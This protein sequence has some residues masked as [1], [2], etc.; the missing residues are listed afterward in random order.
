MLQCRLV[1]LAIAGLMLQVLVPDPSPLLRGGVDGSAAAPSSMLDWLPAAW[2]ATPAYAGPRPTPTPLAALD[3]GARTRMLRQP[4]GKLLFQLSATSLTPQRV[5]GQAVAPIEPPPVEPPPTGPAAAGEG[6]TEPPAADPAP[7]A[8][9]SSKPAAEPAPVVAAPP[10]APTLRYRPAPATAPAPIG[11]GDEKLSAPAPA[12]VT[13]DAAKPFPTESAP[14]RSI[15]D[16]Y[17]PGGTQGAVFAPVPS[18]PLDVTPNYALRE[19]YYQ[20]PKDGFTYEP[21]VGFPV[22]E[23]PNGATRERYS[24][25]PGQGVV[26]EPVR[27]IPTETA[28]SVAMRERY[29]MGDGKNTGI[30]IVATVPAEASPSEA[31][32]G[33][34]GQQVVAQNGNGTVVR[35]KPTGDA[36]NIIVYGSGFAGAERVAIWIDGL[37]ATRGRHLGWGDVDWN[38]DFWVDAVTIPA[39]ETPGLHTIDVVGQ[40][41][42][43]TATALIQLELSP[44]PISGP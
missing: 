18:I 22:D 34:Q 26:M 31:P 13:S 23:S 42:M 38:G 28:A 44:G 36:R 4:G 6:A 3:P 32:K 2:S 35:I 1:R 14:A 27:P 10:P 19:S 21:V 5:E 24:L 17:G 43:R 20:G 37:D 39:D 15:R 9:S 25:G 29:S 16:V 41:S 30:D 12:F 40:K 33:W 11:P 8:E 7:A